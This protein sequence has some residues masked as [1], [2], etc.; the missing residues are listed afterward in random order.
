MLDLPCSSLRTLISWVIRE[1]SLCEGIFVITALV[2]EQ[3]NQNSLS[4]GDLVWTWAACANPLSCDRPPQQA[5]PPCPTLRGSAKVIALAKAQLWSESQAS[6]DLS[7][8]TSA[9]V[10]GAVCQVPG[11]RPERACLSIHT[12]QSGGHC[13]LCRSQETGA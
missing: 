5:A 7:P 12:H 6:S 11:P 13:H 10:L 9:R 4:S 3:L 1:A 2:G 8:R